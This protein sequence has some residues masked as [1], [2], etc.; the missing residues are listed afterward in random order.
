VMCATTGAGARA[1]R[2]GRADKNAVAG[3]VILDREFRVERTF[4]DGAGVQPGGFTSTELKL[5]AAK[6]R[7][8]SRRTFRSACAFG[9]LMRPRGVFLAAFV[10]TMAASVSGRAR[11]RSG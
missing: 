8:P 1:D 6:D 9:G 3:V 10:L 11:S 7:H 5:G 2:A 4:V